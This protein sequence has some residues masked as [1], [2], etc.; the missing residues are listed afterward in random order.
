MSRLRKIELEFVDAEHDFEEEV[1]VEGESS[2][3]EPS[4]D[5]PITAPM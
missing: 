5:R 4:R 2:V 1:G 3:A